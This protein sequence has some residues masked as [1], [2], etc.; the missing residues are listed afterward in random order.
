MGSELDGKRSKKE[1]VVEA[2]LKELF[3]NKP[4]DYDKTVM[5]GDRKF[6]VEGAK[7]Y[8]L[9]SIGVGYGYA[10]KQELMDA[11]P[12]FYVATVKEL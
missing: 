12:D 4:I 10:G 11:G 5:V 3:P 8:G 9:M 2:C 6:D 1:D 7:A